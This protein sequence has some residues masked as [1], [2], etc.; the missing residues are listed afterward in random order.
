MSRSPPEAQPSCVRVCVMKWE[1]ES[2]SDVSTVCHAVFLSHAH[3][4]EQLSVS[5]HM[6]PQHTHL[7]HAGKQSRWAGRTRGAGGGGAFD[8]RP[9]TTHHWPS[10]K[11]ILLLIRHGFECYLTATLPSWEN[12]PRTHCRHIVG[13]LGSVSDTGM[14]FDL[15]E[16]R[17]KPGRDSQTRGEQW[18]GRGRRRTHQRES[19]YCPGASRGS[20]ETA[21]CQR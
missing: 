6:Q 7:E 20:S 21:V 8:F 5:A 13:K 19:L 17:I 4:A 12:W 18:R 1:C 2:L 15:T 3:R 16:K 10:L 11:K 9:F 14:T